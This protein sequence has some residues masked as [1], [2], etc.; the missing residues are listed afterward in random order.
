MKPKFKD[1]AAWE[2]AQ[3]LMQPIFIRLVDNIRKKLED[4]T[5]KGTYE[6]RQNPVPGY[7]LTLTRS[8]ESYTFNLWE[9]CYS[10][11]FQNYQI[12]HAPHTPV[13]VEIDTDLFQVETGDIDW[14]KIEAKTKQVV[15]EV[16]ATL[17]SL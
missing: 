15:E 9:M 11:C 12:T 13:E 14:N 3:Q 1:I 17:P 6:E 2:Q 4:S 5:W 16:F 7:E 8:Q 10:I